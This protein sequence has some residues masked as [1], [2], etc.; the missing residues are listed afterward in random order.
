MTDEK[1][2]E[3]S[4][5]N[6]VLVSQSEDTKSQLSSLEITLTEITKKFRCKLDGLYEENKKLRMNLKEEKDRHKVEIEQIT[7]VEKEHVVKKASSL[8]SRSRKRTR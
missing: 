5:S 7:G 3:I 1:I 2:T 6:A 8:D 4:A